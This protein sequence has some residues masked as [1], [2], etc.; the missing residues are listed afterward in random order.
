MS[1]ENSNDF[2][3]PLQHT[4]KSLRKIKDSLAPFLDLLK[5]HNLQVKKSSSL[6]SFPRSPHHNS[7]ENQLNEHQV[8]EA[9]A[10][11]ALSIGTLRY[12]AARLKGLSMG[13]KKNDP[14]RM[15][16]DNM[17]KTLVAVQK[18]KKES[19]QSNPNLSDMKK[20]A[21]TTTTAA[22]STNEFNTG[23]QERCEDHDDEVED[24]TMSPIND[25]CSK[26]KIAS[27]DDGHNNGKTNEDMEKKENDDEYDEENDS[28][29]IRIRNKKLKN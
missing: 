29:C 7:R 5:R 21:G 4:M 11:I 24:A 13:Q 28:L 9:Q 6:S 16:L 25:T 26:R 22:T 8:A 12:M 27:V 3:L 15:E 20:E 14:L 19:E 1:N 17:R 18:L 10:A 2:L 23:K